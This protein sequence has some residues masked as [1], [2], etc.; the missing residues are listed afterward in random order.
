MKLGGKLSKW[1]ENFLYNRT[2]KVVVSREESLSVSVTSDVPQGTVLGPS[3]F[4]IYINDLPNSVSSK[5]SLLAGDSYVCRPIINTLDCKQLQKDLDNMMKW[6]KEWSM[7]F[8]PSKCKVLIVTKKIRPVQHC[9]K[10]HGIYLWNVTQEK[11]LRVML[12]RKL[13]WKPHVS[14]VVAKANYTRYFFQQNL[15][16]CLRDVKL[17]RYK[18]YVRPIVEYASTVLDP[19]SKDLQCKVES[20][21][22]K[23]ARWITNDSRWSSCPTKILE[24][25]GLRKLQERRSIAKLKMLHS[26]YHSYKFVTPSLLPL[27]ARNANLQFKPILGPVECLNDRFSHQ[28]LHWGINCHH[29]L[30]TLSAWNNS[31]I[32]YLI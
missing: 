24:E 12:H 17:K 2:K 29:I 1:V 20:V 11:Y 28:L 10:M 18:T 25:V 5:I 8:N 4:L 21:Q 23:A 14:N 27:K 7:E 26:F 32:M 13:C 22:R 3:L 6:E 19:N 16:T 31:L 15:S 30:P 9:Y